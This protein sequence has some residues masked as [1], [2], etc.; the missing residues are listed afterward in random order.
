MTK[1]RL[2]DEAPPPAHGGRDPMM[3]SAALLAPRV[4]AVLG[5][6]ADRAKLGSTILA[7]VIGNGFDGV[8]YGI[9][10]ESFELP[11]ARIVRCIDEVPE[12]IDVLLLAVP[13]AALAASIA[14]IPPG[15]VRVAVAIASGFS[16]TGEQGAAMEAEV[17]RA[18]RRSGLSLIGPNCQGVVVPGARLQMTFSPMYNRMV[19]GPVAV[20]SQSGAMGGFMVN[21]LMQRGVGI[22]CFISS[23]NE[24]DL[25]AADYIAAFGAQADTRVLLCYLEQIRD[26]RRFAAAVRSLPP[27]KRLVAIKCGRT[28]AGAAAVRSHTGAIA[29]D[30]RIVD[31]VFEQLGVLRAPDSAA[32]V[33]AAAA[34]AAGKTLR[35]LR[36][37]ILSIAGGLAVELADLLEMRGFEVPPFCDATIERLRGIVPAF[38]ATRNPIDLT[39]AVLT[40]DTLFGNALDVMAAD[41]GLDGYVIISTYVR[42]PRIAQAIIAL[43]RRSDKPVIVCWTG[44]ADQTPESLQLL[45]AAGVPVYDATARG[46]WAMHALRPRCGDEPTVQDASVP[47]GD[48]AWQPLRDLLQAWRAA[49]RIQVNE[50][51]SKR[52]LGRAGLPLPAAPSPGAN[53]VVKLCADSHLHKT[54]FDLLRLRVPFERIETIGA[55][56]RARGDQLGIAD[57][58]LLYEAMVDDGLLEWFVGC[59]DDAQMG[60][61]IVLGVGG[62]YAE[63]FGA[64]LIRMAPLSVADAQA[65]IRSHPAYPIIAGARKRPPADL[66]GFAAIVASASELF[67]AVA[68]LVDEIDLNPI[69]VR[70]A[71]SGPAAVIAD[72]AIVLKPGGS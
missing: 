42:D 2:A 43:H 48:A 58:A 31:G 47:A 59:K 27:G 67:V 23:G 21:R 12:P 7:N 44:G 18:C 65:L 35:G 30:D 49:G 17:L 20:I 50:F 11:G 1:S 9:G 68:D 5:V 57:A 19:A 52:V 15:K 34:L 60:P 16:E 40:D 41:P 70:P 56:L 29:V 37:G 10:R 8:I 24:I 22:S 3:A 69:I 66:Q 26:G 38:G 33:D 25:Q 64:P 55:E 71:G 32:A 53:A 14:Q 4:V 6:S 39:G 72:A 46:A 54:E 45:A 63:L 36:I 51:D 13:A 28:D 62:I 61:I